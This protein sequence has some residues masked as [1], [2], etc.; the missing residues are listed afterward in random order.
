MRIVILGTGA[1]GCVFAA[2]LAPCVEVWMLGTW[3][4]GVAAVQRDGVCLRERDGTRRCARLPATTDPADVPPADAVLLLV[5]SY[6][7]ERAAAWAARVL[8][9]DGLAITL[10]NGLDSD[11][12]LRSAVGGRRA[13]VGVTYN[14]AILLGPGEA[15]HTTRLA[16]HLGAHPAVAGRVAALA[17]RFTD[18]GLE[19]HVAAEIEPLLWVK[20]LANVAINPL[21]ALWRVPNG[22][23][24]ETAERRALLAALVGEAAAVA[25]ARGIALPFADPV[26]H[27]EAVCRATAANRS[28][29]L[30]DVERGRPTEIDSLNG[31]IVAEGRRLGVPTPVNEVVWRLVRGVAGE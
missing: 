30:Q 21:T 28:S 6:Q 16:T 1:L 2:R 8:K 20:A 13:T 23:P 31:V 3:A 11:A 5:K 10:Q 22:G 9:P 14:G 29:M 17:G 25:R 15:Y 19:T 12:K 26:A 18:C 27:V 24:L 7:T 4:A